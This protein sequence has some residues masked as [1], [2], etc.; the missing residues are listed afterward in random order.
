MA[1]SVGCPWP[2]PN[3]PLDCLHR[4]RGV[5]GDLAGD[6]VG[7]LHQ[8]AHGAELVDHAEP[9]GLLGGDRVAG[10]Q[11][12]QGL[13]RREHAGKQCRRAAAGGQADHRFGLAE[14][15]VVGRDDEVGALGDLA[16]AAVGDAVDR[17]EDRL[18]QLAKGVEG[19]VEVLAL[20]QPVLLG[21]VLALA[22]VAADREGPVT[23]A[24]DDGDAD[25]GTDG[26]RLQ[27]LR[28]P[29]PHL[30]GDRVVG[31]WPVQGDERHLPPGAVL[32]QH[33]RVR[34]RRSGAW[35]AEVECLPAVGACRARCHLAILSWIAALFRFP[36][37]PASA[38]LA[39]PVRSS[40]PRRG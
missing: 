25:G 5:A 33:G 13:A 14:G 31:V 2:R 39:G 21:H 18:A 16:A 28:Q 26:D 24:G 11:H 19:A 34:L 29:R 38:A 8:L 9:V 37:P 36:A 3:G 35:R 4:R 7:H 30:R 1:C 6:P 22:Q 10:H 27:D 32:D 17:G 20:P 23:R 15:R 12:L 40:T